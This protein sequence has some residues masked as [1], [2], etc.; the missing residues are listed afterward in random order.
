MNTIIYITKR[1]IAKYC[2]NTNS[3]KLNAIKS[4]SVYRA[5][6]NAANIKY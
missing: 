1:Q 5:V 6:S 4:K 2:K 3:V